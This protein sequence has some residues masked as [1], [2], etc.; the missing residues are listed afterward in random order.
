MLLTTVDYLDAKVE[1]AAKGRPSFSGAGWRW[2][3][4][5]EVLVQYEHIKHVKLK[6]LVSIA[7]RR[8]GFPYHRREVTTSVP[9]G[10]AQAADNIEH[11]ELELWRGKEK[12]RENMEIVLWYMCLWYALHSS[13]KTQRKT[14]ENAA[15]LS[16]INPPET[17]NGS[18]CIHTDSS[19][20]RTA[21]Y[22]R[23][24]VHFNHAQSTTVLGFCWRAPQTAS[25]LTA[26]VTKLICVQI[27]TWAN[28]TAS[29]NKITVLWFL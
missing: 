22:V 28:V 2:K 13:Q 3:E 9:A 12:K 18:Y 7:S 17:G 8:W 23:F 5:V 16:P 24:N 6:G 26:D 14:A 1:A 21:Q 10:P 15:Q 20:Y 27:Q 11:L 29:Y 4:R 19:T 25:Q